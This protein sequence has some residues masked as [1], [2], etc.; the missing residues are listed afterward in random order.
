M[1]LDLQI[2]RHI[3]GHLAGGLLLALVT[4]LPIA[5]NAADIAFSDFCDVSAL[6]LNGSTATLTPNPSCVLRLTNYYVQSGSA[7]TTQPFSLAA[8]ASFSTA[9]CFRISDP[10]G[11]FDVD[12][13]GADG[14]AF[15]VQ[16]QA[17]N[18][19]GSGGGM[20]YDGIRPSVAVEFDTYENVFDPDGN[21]I[22]IALNGDVTGAGSLPWPTRL[23]DGALSCSWVDYDGVAKRMEVRHAN[24]STR[25]TEALMTQDVDLPQV[26]GTTDAFLGFT[27]GTGSG[28]GTH[29]ILSWQLTG[30]YAPIECGDGTIDAG[31]A[32]DDGDVE[33]MD[34]CSADCTIESD[35]Q[36]SGEPS[37]CVHLLDCIGQPQGAACED[38]IV[39]NGSDSCD[40]SGACSVHSGSPCNDMDPCTE[41]TCY[42]AGQCDYVVVFESRA[43]LTCEDG[44]D[45]DDSGDTD[46]DDA[47]CATLS[48]SQEF[49]VLGRAA[50]GK[51]VFLGS[52]LAITSVDG[53]VPD[54]DG[55][56]FPIGPSR[57]SVCGEAKMNVLAGVQ[58]A[59]ALVAAANQSI[60]FG[61]GGDTNIG[62]GYQD[63]PS[64]LLTLTGVPPV[65]GPGF[66][67]GD[68]SPCTLDADCAPPA[69]TCEGPLLDDFGNGSVDHSGTTSQFL[70]CGSAKAA[71]MADTT[72]AFGLVGQT[73][74]SITYKVGD[75]Q[76][77]PTFNGPGVHVVRVS[78]LR[79][80]GNASLTVTADDPG[81]I[82]VIQV[83]KGLSVGKGATV[84]V[85]GQLKPENVLW[86]TPG[87]GSV[88]ILGSSNFVGTVLGP[89]RT[90]KV[91]QNVMIEGSLLGGKVKI[92]G[93]TTI[94]HRPFTALL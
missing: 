49:A 54:P 47:A 29:D 85:G 43:C 88:K 25:P 8:D 6:T 36:C 32:C 58:I 45:N 93:T 13:V 92:N 19:G 35:W 59:G 1:H 78:K 51:S 70:R 72:Y 62:F 28:F 56:P 27:S 52:Q 55:A 82:V 34:G 80:S 26:L 48:E 73:L 68:M 53:S 66:C 39:C 74:P 3:R 11:T 69:S 60:V 7:F 37:T 75:P 12:G 30:S 81:A 79:V 64:T 89:E 9:F 77:L 50:I 86:V 4:L 16:T 20:G 67:S 5:A 10:G 57:A 90:I 24:S 22:G 84:Q 23:N 17:N 33:D 44:Y 31:E 76:P 63:A 46:A 94:S 38:G 83:E 21:H 87:K 14:L 71:L 15:V 42:G 61:S 41:D 40:G 2:S 65:V 18:A 91:G